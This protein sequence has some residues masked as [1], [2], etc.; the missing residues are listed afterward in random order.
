MG[1]KSYVCRSYS[2][3]TGKGGGG[4]FAPPIPSWIGLMVQTFASHKSVEGEFQIEWFCY[5]NR[6]LYPKIYCSKSNSVVKILVERVI[7][8][9]LIWNPNSRTS[10][11]QMLF[12]IGVLKNYAN[13]PGKHLCRSLFLIRACNFVKKSLQHRCFPVKFA[14]F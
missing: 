4:L 8:I 9:S 10:R 1:T 3:K 6:T 11:S 2:G 14:K 5:S 7:C 13:F 12:K